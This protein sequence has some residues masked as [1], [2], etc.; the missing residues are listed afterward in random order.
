[1]SGGNGF[2]SDPIQVVI[3]ALVLAGILLG[4]RAL[5]RVK[6][7]EA[8]SAALAA[9]ESLAETRGEQ[10][11]DLQAAIAR[12]QGVIERAQDELS[13][14]MEMNKQL[15]L[16]DQTAVLKYLDTQATHQTERFASAMEQVASLFEHHETR[17]NERH[18]KL[19]GA[20]DALNRRLNGTPQGK[21]K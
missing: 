8:T 10:V 7:Q 12:Q 17:A 20:F 1:M 4:A 11:K 14:A 9:A 5:R 2:F 3:A 15:K 19:I 6:T 18:A 16:A 13:K 21:E